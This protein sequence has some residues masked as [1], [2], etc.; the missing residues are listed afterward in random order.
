[1][2]ART[3]NKIIGTALTMILVASI[4]AIGIAPTTAA[5]AQGLGEEAAHQIGTVLASRLNVRSGPGV[6]N[7]TLGDLKQFAPLALA[8]SLAGSVPGHRLSFGA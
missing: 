5:Q 3:K 2:Q 7:S 6:T 8:V 1:M 4:A